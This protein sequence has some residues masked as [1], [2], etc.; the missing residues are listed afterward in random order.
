V[1]SCS[2]YA[3][4]STCLCIAKV[5]R[6]PQRLEIQADADPFLWRS[7]SLPAE[8]YGPSS[9]PIVN[10]EYIGTPKGETAPDVSLA[11]R[12]EYLLLTCV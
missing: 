3:S 6:P 5:A 2:R 7:M 10:E 8:P 12:V 11:L 4:K 1:F 9:L